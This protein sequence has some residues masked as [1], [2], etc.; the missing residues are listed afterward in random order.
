MKKRDDGVRGSKPIAPDAAATAPVSPRK[1]LGS[2]SKI[3]KKGSANGKKNTDKRVAQTSIKSHTSE[4]SELEDEKPPTPMTLRAQMFFES[5]ETK[6]H[7]KLGKG[8]KSVSVDP[9]FTGSMFNTN[10]SSPNDKLQSGAPARRVGAS[11]SKKN[12]KQGFV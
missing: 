12:G 5:L 1:M 3:K 6:P 4:D 8:Y 7:Y 10:P 9:H 2:P 11:A